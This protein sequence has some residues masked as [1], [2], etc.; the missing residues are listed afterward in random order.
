MRE[1]LG[2]GFL[3]LWIRC[4]LWEMATLCTHFSLIPLYVE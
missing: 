4:S 3:Y 1:G 2:R